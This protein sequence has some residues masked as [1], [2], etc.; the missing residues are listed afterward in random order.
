[1]LMDSTFFKQGFYKKADPCPDVFIKKGQ[2]DTIVCG[3]QAGRAGK[4]DPLAS[5]KACNLHVSELH[6]VIV[7]TK[8]NG[9]RGIYEYTK[10]RGCLFSNK[11]GCHEQLLPKLVNRLLVDHLKKEKIYDIVL[12]GEMFL[13]KCEVT[14]KG[15][16]K[17][18]V[19]DIGKQHEAVVGDHPEFLKNCNFTY[20][21][22]DILRLN[23]TDVSQMALE[24]R[25]GMLKKV[26]PKS[27]EAN[28]DGI[29]M[30]GKNVSV[31][32]I[33][34]KMMSSVEEIA[35]YACEK[36]VKGEEGVVI[37]EPDQPY[38]WKGRTEKNPERS[39][40]YKL[41]EQL[42]IDAEVMRAC[43][44][45]V[46]KTGLH[47]FRYRNLHL[48]VCADV[49]CKNLVPI[50]DKGASLSVTGGDFS[51]LAKWDRN[52]Q[53]P[54]LQMIKNG[55]VKPSGGWR[56]VDD[57]AKNIKVKHST[58]D[59]L[60]AN[61]TDGSGKKGL[62]TCVNLPLHE[63]ILSVV[64]TDVN[65]NANGKPTLQGPPKLHILRKD[66]KVPNDVNYVLSL[67]GER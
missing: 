46:G 12:D 61:I 13:E 57:V 18:V 14:R 26:L 28:V 25:K 41:K 56:Y 39:G 45:N 23:G 47:A 52:V 2:E 22:F 43:L 67:L 1:M 30:L 58:F 4:W 66:K 32:P 17:L 44:G 36:T 53:D 63:M 31:D 38:D 42:D 7:E 5:V 59:D 49:D 21:T 6:P 9:H 65:V 10:G 50:T 15:E 20:K 60:V 40:W 27:L 24:T 35:K 48:G 37:K 62:P 54:I 34:G 29:S 8:F 16:K 19:P 11:T 55:R 3:K 33:H 51:G 64:G